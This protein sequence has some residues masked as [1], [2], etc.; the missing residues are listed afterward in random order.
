MV[1]DIRNITLIK[2]IKEFPES[3]PGGALDLPI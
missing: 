3:P 2:K 1:D